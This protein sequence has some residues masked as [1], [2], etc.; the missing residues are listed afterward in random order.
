VSDWWDR[1]WRA[2]PGKEVANQPA[3]GPTC[4]WCSAPAEPGATYCPS[5]G[6]V[7][8]QRE[9]LDGLVIP[10][11][12]DVDPASREL[13]PTAS[14]LGTP[15]RVNAFGAVGQAAGQS[16]P[17]TGAAP[18]AAGD[19]ITGG[20]V[21]PVDPKDRGSVAPAALEMTNQLDSAEA[22]LTPNM[23]DRPDEADTSSDQPA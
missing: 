7:M 22:E 18:A 10:G 1:P 11:V 4:P 12:T 15:A 17:L 8:A 13:S 2:E 21:A 20:S 5:C 14:R 16:A 23:G 9:S 19:S 3:R 6:A